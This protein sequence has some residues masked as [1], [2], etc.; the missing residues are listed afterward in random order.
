MLRE[1]MRPS[2]AGQHST[3]RHSKPPN[4]YF[5]A[6]ENVPGAG[7]NGESVGRSSGVV[8][9]GP[10]L[11]ARRASFPISRSDVESGAKPVGQEESTGRTRTD[12]ADGMNPPVD[13]H[14]EKRRTGAPVR[15]SSLEPQDSG[16]GTVRGSASMRS[17]SLPASRL[18]EQ[19]MGK[20]TE[21]RGESG[22]QNVRLRSQF[23]GGLVGESPAQ[24]QEKSDAPGRGPTG[25]APVREYSSSR[26][27][28]R[29]AAAS[30][31]TPANYSTLQTRPAILGGSQT[32]RDLA[33]LTSE[34]S[35]RSPPG[36]ARAFSPPRE[37]GYHA[38]GG[39]LDRGTSFPLSPDPM[40]T[41]APYVQRCPPRR[42]W[43]V[44]RAPVLERLSSDPTGSRA[45]GS[46]SRSPSARTDHRGA[47]L[48]KTGSLPP[49]ESGALRE[50]RR[51]ES[52]G[53]LRRPYC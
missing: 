25:P 47:A 30:R 13:A 35:M 48:Y 37:A 29:A 12:V 36:S 45:G 4:T 34:L 39:S 11:S 15:S 1:I 44:S 52:L 20:D 41:S 33:R 3:L 43:Q 51:A 21:R 31:P 19:H 50:W 24:P 28:S 2:T 42:D 26:L 22:A 53:V 17:R 8:P 46:L 18:N 6:R 10:V 49:R 9:G 14:R 5:P 27:A 16:N 40:R 7:G 32:S 38:P 23:P